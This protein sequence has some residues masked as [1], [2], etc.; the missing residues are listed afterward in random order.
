MSAK[1]AHYDDRKQRKKTKFFQVNYTPFFKKLYLKIYLR[2]YFS[3]K[4]V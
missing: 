3:K 1:N 4:N 2:P